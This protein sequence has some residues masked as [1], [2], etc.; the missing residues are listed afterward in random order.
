MN[1]Q[2][3]CIIRNIERSPL[4]IMKMISGGNLYIHKG[5]KSTKMVNTWVNMKDDCVSAQSLSPIQL[6]VIPETVQHIRLL[7]PWDFLAR[8]L[9]LVAISCSRGSSPPRH[10]TYAS[11]ISFI[12]KQVLYHSTLGLGNPNMKDIIA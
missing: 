8:I 6:F 11:C 10:Q 1:S 4:G 12:G 9:E 2:Q 7:C 5:T 3:N